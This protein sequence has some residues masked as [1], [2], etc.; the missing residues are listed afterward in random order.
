MTRTIKL[1]N[2]EA[3]LKEKITHDVK[4]AHEAALMKGVKLSIKPGQKADDALDR[5][6]LPFENTIA[7]DEA[8]VIGLLVKLTIDGKDME[9]NKQTIGELDA[10]DYDL[11]KKEVNAIFKPAGKEEALE[12]KSES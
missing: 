10:A 8:L 2:G 5:L 9:I 11:I 12:K 7:A 4:S 6:E 1:S 3:I